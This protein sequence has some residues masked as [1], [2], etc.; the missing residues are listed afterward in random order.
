MT[1]TPRGTSEIADYRLAVERHLSDLPAPIREDLLSDL[2]EHLT[3]VAADMEPGMTL[4]DLLGTPEVY[5]REL[6]E[7][8]GVERLPASERFV[9]GL[10][11]IMDP[12]FSGLHG[13]AD[14]FTTSAGVGEAASFRKALKPGWWV[15]RGL[16][17]AA[18]VSYFVMATD[19]GMLQAFRTFGLLS[20]AL[21]GA[22]ALLFVWLSLRLGV[23]SERWSRG[24]RLMVAGG[25]AALLGVAMLALIAVADTILFSPAVQY[26]ANE[27]YPYVEDVHVYS[28]DGELL[29]GVY[30]FDQNGEPLRLGDPGAC[31]D[32]ASSNPFEEPE[33]PVGEGYTTVDPGRYGYQYP[34][35]MP[36]ED[37]TVGPQ[38]SPSPVESAGPEDPEPGS[39]EPTS[40]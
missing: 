17:A 10:W 11:R 21:C 33:T 35:C 30:L 3:E 5:A 20:L 8:A 1:D 34:L 15:L 24:N 13:A 19:E 38:E 27:T 39:A 37:P 36:G 18:L 25:G 26:H 16:I 32:E 9:R 2:E 29:T 22:L 31:F 14:R 6:R 12:T 4:A 28:E 7:T 40:E 23:R